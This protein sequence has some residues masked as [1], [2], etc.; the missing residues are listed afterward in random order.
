M[1]IRHLKLIISEICQDHGIYNYPTVKNFITCQ[2]AKKFRNTI[3]K[4]NINNPLKKMQI[5]KKIEQEPYY[6]GIDVSLYALR[7]K[8]SFKHIEYG[9]LR[10]IIQSLSAG[11]IPVYVFDGSAPDQKRKTI[12]ARQFKKQKMRSKIENIFFG[13][14]ESIP[15]YVSEMS[16][17][18]LLQHISNTYLK[19]YAIEKTDTDILVDEFTY[20]V[21]DIK[22]DNEEL[23]HEYREILKLSKK[24]ISID[25]NDIKKIQL[26]LD[27]LKIPYFVAGGEADDLLA[28]LS[29][30]GIIDACQSDD[31]DM[32][33]KGC[34]N[35]IQISKNGVTQYVLSEILE[36]IELSYAEFVDMCIL[37]GSDYYTCYLPKM[38]PMDLYYFFKSSD[39]SSIENFVSK[40]S[41]IDSRINVHLDS[42]LHTRKSY[43]LEHQHFDLKLI[44]MAPLCLDVIEQYMTSHRIPISDKYKNKIKLSL[45]GIND[46]INLC[47]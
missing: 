2:K 12:I 1:G 35:V 4:N 19:M 9:F 14:C 46:F 28:Y 32:L 43:I 13:N 21:S 40:Y 17:E 42:Y 33:P 47:N 11:I 30:E 7:Y 16:I 20:S 36:K 41:Q 45:T 37:L 39:I 44:K 25:H 18:E 29:K 5:K 22:F 6:V 23:D 26:F 27:T 8:R 38:K 15:E 24:S 10:Q 31:M 34:H 3:T